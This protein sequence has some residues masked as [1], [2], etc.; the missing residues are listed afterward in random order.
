MTREN[1]R[2]KLDL[3]GIEKTRQ[4]SLIEKV[5]FNPVKLMGKRKVSN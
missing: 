4:N 3:Y 5:L 1:N 2:K